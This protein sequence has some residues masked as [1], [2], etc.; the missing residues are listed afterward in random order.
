MK[1]E[2]KLG[3]F[4][5]ELKIKTEDGT[6]FCLKPKIVHKRKL[7]ALFAK[8]TQDGKATE[9]DL[10]KEDEQIID[11]L[12]QAYPQFNENQINNIFM[13]YGG[14]ILLE[15][16]FAWKWRDKKTWNLLKAQQD[17]KLKELEDEINSPNN[18]RK[19]STD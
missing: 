12:K 11:M 6:E 19:Q 15:L 16:Y 18:E 3:E 2:D 8:K 14:E 17:K 7:M 13:E 4:V 5:G 10:E 9:Q 1:I